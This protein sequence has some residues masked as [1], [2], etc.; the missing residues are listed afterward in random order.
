MFL[1]DTNI[2]SELR[3]PAPS[4][5]VVAWLLAVPADSV[6][7]SAVTLYELQKGVENL[8]RRDPARARLIEQWIDRVAAAYNVLPMDGPAFRAHARLMHRR[9]AAATEDS[10]IAATAQVHN[11]SIATRNVRDFKSLG[12]KVLNP[13]EFAG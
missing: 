7:V 12:V 5:N 8:R 3:A 13:F 1:I 11:L 4:A 2:L 6:F 10:M 9:A